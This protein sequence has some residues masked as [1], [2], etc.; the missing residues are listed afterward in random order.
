MTTSPLIVKTSNLSPIWPSLAN[1]LSVTIQSLNSISTWPSRVRSGPQWRISS[2][3]RA[4]APVTRLE[5]LSSL[6]PT[7]RRNRQLP[8]KNWLSTT[9]ECLWADP[10]STSLRVLQQSDLC[11][12]W[13]S[14]RL[15]SGVTEHAQPHSANSLLILQMHHADHS[16]LIP[17]MIFWKNDCCCFAGRGACWQNQI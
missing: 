7:P 15:S 5:T 1:L 12:L 6:P 4:M 3:I 10:R 11:K 2:Y 13:S 17:T 16:D 8:P 14:Q 9:R